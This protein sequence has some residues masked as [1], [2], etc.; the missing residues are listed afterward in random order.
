MKI[1]V[2]GSLK[3]VE[4]NGSLC[5]DFV[6]RLGELIMER[7]HILLNGCSGSLDKMIAESANA[8]LIKNKLNPKK[9]IISYINEGNE[10]N[11]THDV[12]EIIYSEYKDW[13]FSRAGR[14]IPEQI[15]QSD[16]AIFIGGNEG[17][18]MAANFARLASP[19]KPIL[20]IGTFGGAGL[21][22]FKEEREPFSENY[23]FLLNDGL[24][25]E[26][27]NIAPTQNSIE[28]LVLN[29]LK[30]CE[31]LM[32]SRKVFTIMSFAQVYKDVYESFKS[33]CDKNGYQTYR[34]DEDLTT[35]PIT[36]RIL[37]GIKQSDFIIAD[38]SELKPNVFYEIGYAKGIRR[39][40]ILTA[41][42]EIK[43][44][45]PFDVKDLPVI[46]YDRLD[47]TTT[48]EPALDKFI[49]EIRKNKL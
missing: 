1:Y 22:L 27:L 46:F 32:Q 5:D 42:K 26:N 15:S 7:G 11:K 21:D 4:K 34:T 33:I 25:Y 44:D 39:E 48:L 29:T 18:N 2:G 24:S 43:A 47:M 41:K 14:E 8:F 36:P 30:I 20:G 28:D 10:H 9:R 19:P 37:E 45:L 3:N 31:C 17:T 23:S 49:K 12:G 40:V 6:T 13:S 35:S 16:V 38:I